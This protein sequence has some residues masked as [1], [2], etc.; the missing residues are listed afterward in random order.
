[1]LHFVLRNLRVLI[2]WHFPLFG[3]ESV[4]SLPKEGHLRI[5]GRWQH[6]NAK[7]PPQSP[8]TKG[9]VEH[10]RHH[11]NKVFLSWPFVE[12]RT[13]KSECTHCVAFPP[14]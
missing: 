9:E 10:G 1:M 4:L 13:A 3:E 6:A 2:A 7:N 14:S 8:F 12:F 11:S 5:C